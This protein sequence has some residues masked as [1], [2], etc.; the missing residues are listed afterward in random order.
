MKITTLLFDVG[1][2]LFN[3]TEYRSTALNIVIEKL[4]D[5]GILIG[6]VENSKS[7]FEELVTKISDLHSDRFFLTIDFFKELFEK[8]KLKVDVK[9]CH[10]AFLIY[11]DT[12]RFL[13]KP[14]TDINRLF[15]DLK[16]KGYKLGIITDGSLD[17]AYEILLRLGIV[18][19]FDTIVVSEEVGV[20]KPD[21]KIFHEALRRL[22]SEPTETIMIGDNLERDIHGGKQLGMVTVL[23]QRYKLQEESETSIKPDYKIRRL[24][25]LFKILN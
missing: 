22:K 6:N 9:L 3:L 20:E 2:T 1:D 21:T 5:Q 19:F 18:N 4:V 15:F 14:S 17:S 16:E 12:L 25:E 11:R 10:Y 24:D 23:M 13:L 8:M 7:L